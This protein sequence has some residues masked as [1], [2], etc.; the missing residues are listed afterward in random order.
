[1]K[2]SG[3]L[4]FAFALLLILSIFNPPITK[5]EITS[6]EP[7]QI[8]GQLTGINPKYIPT[9]PE[10]AQRIADEIKNDY[11]KK[12]W[13]KI[14]ENNTFY[15]PIHK[16]LT[17]YPLVSI[18]ILGQ[19][20][21]FSVSFFCVFIF[22][23]L[24][25]FFIADFLR[26]FDIVK[27]WWPSF[28]FGILGAEILAHVGLTRFIVNTLLDVILNRHNIWTRLLLTAV[29]VIFIIALFFLSNFIGKM[30]KQTKEKNRK[31]EVEHAG[32]V[33]KETSK[34]ITETKDRL[35]KKES[36]NEDRESIL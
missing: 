30:A 2:K 11:L 28:G 9:S 25:I 23:L 31:E 7:N 36:S 18:I 34:G 32:D 13:A 4:I 14:I 26:A 17:N 22:W 20:Y 29:F 15:S 3:V 16:F 12:E 10:D 24:T 21:E 1:M 19:S 5:A 8:V 33:L 6:P 27:T 35:K